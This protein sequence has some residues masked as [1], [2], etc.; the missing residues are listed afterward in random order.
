M[1]NTPE[2]WAAEYERRLLLQKTFTQRLTELIKTLL[3]DRTIEVHAIDGRTKSTHS[4]HE[5]IR[6]LGK[7]YAN[8]LE[9][10]MD[11]TGIRVIVY[12]NHDVDAVGQLL[13]EEFDIDQD[14]SADRRKLLQPHEFGCQS[15]HYVLRLSQRR[16]ALSEWKTFEPLRA[17]IQVRTVLQH[18]WAAISHKLQYKRE[19][20]IPRELSR[21]LF[22]LSALLELADDEFA[23]LQGQTNDVARRIKEQ[24]RAGEDEIPLNLVSLEE[25]LASAPEMRPLVDHACTLGFHMEDDREPSAR[26]LNSESLGFFRQLDITTVGQLSRL[27][28]EARPWAVQ[29]LSALYTKWQRWKMSPGFIALLIIVAVHKDRLSVEQLV[30]NQ[31]DG[32]IATDAL[33]AAHAVTSGR[34]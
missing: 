29:Y 34:E 17:E 26:R 7:S 14:H 19:E 16:I 27:I 11:L 24:L 32:S 12:Y 23:S 31:W 18:A 13:E 9:E 6:R 5:K 15:V 22:R 21:K 1:I 33:E 30:A 28:R 8:P 3:S 20:D 10:A 25:Y 4:F 2:E